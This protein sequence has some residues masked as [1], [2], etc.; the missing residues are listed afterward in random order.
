MCTRSITCDFPDWPDHAGAEAH[1]FIPEGESSV[2]NPVEVD[3]LLTPAEVAAMLYVDPKT[4]TRWA[5]AGKI[6]CIR[7]PGGH[8][9]FLSSEI[10]ALATSASSRS[11][12]WSVAGQPAPF[13]R[14][15]AADVQDLNPRR[16]ALRYETSR[17][18]TEAVVARAVA[19]ARE[20]QAVESARAVI[21]TRFAVE[22]AAKIV[23]DS[24]GKARA[25]RASAA[26]TAAQA[27]ASSADRAA[28]AVQRQADA[29]ATTLRDAATRAARIV[30]AA[31]PPGDDHE[32][33]LAAIRLAMSTQAAA[34]ATARDT[35]AAAV[36]VATAVAAAA[37]D[38]ARMV[39]DLDV[40]IEGEVA[41]VAAAVQTAATARA[42]Q[43]AAELDAQATHVAT[44]A[45]EA[46]AAVNLQRDQDDAALQTEPVTTARPLPVPAVVVARG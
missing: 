10:L 16:A 43:V 3:A 42:R 18:A 19:V 45:R 26:A 12:A 1:R 23:A 31:S 5:M 14:T 33:A 11:S 17:H 21:S 40:A 20:A 28:A 34:V 46:V 41:E 35:A 9:R 37:A 7:T 22:A 6:S 39:A 24:A 2:R 32:T 30:A 25:S 29:S 38:V 8:R 4:V 15:P 13:P 36:D 44:V 27:A